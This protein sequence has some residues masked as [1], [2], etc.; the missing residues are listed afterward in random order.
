MTKINAPK[1]PEGMVVQDDPQIPEENPQFSQEAPAE[2][3]TEFEPEGLKVAKHVK[4]PR[5]EAQDK[6]PYYWQVKR[7]AGNNISAVNSSTGSTFS[8]PHKE[9][10]E[11]FRS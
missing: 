2:E 1:A 8:G 4:G 9:L 5:L 11:Y 7:E 10:S 6:A 3:A